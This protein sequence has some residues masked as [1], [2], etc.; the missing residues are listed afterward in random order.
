MR[1]IETRDQNCWYVDI[2]YITFITHHIFF[3]EIQLLKG[4][5]PTGINQY[6]WLARYESLSRFIKINEVNILHIL[7]IN[8]SIHRLVYDGQFHCGGSLLTQDYVLTVRLLLIF[9]LL[10]YIYSIKFICLTSSSS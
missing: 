9:L 10:L 7:L 3:S 1:S 8:P 2:I 6:P 5:R 4:G